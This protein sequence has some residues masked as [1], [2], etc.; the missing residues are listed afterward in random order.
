MDNRLTQRVLSVSR[1][2]IAVLGGLVALL[3]L[4]AIPDI[5]HRDID[6][7]LTLQL[8]TVPENISA[9][10]RGIFNGDSWWFHETWYERSFWSTM[11]PRMV[12]SLFYL[13]TS[14][15]LA[16]ALGL[17]VGAWLTASRR[18]GLREIVTFA[19]AVPDFVLALLLQIAVVA[20]YKSTGVRIARVASLT[21]AEPALLLPLI[22]LTVVPA[23]YL[24]RT[25][26]ARAY[27]VAA[28]D[29][30]LV[31]KA[32]GIGRLRIWVNQVMPNLTA[33]VRA[34]LAKI[35]GMMIANFFIVEYLFSLKGV[36]A[37]VFSF[38]ISYSYQY[39]L[40]MNSFLLMILMYA[41]MYLTLRVFVR[42]VDEAARRL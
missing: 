9:Y 8:N 35:C 1:L 41:I 14:G 27:V 38:G 4:A 39:D 34:D 32:T 13:L 5:W 30:V 15:L 29:Y 31:A 16:T 17:T 24:L 18:D 12:R 7:V 37:L 19:G 21:N 25:V 33:F 3:L 22:A 2:A 36:T 26:S 11:W 28:E 6:G 42:V 10:L 23:V 20:V 40:V